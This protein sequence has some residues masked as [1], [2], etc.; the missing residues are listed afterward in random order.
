MK[1]RKQTD[2]KKG[3]KSTLRNGKVAWK[4]VPY[5]YPVSFL[6]YS[7]KYHLIKTGQSLQLVHYQ[8][9]EKETEISTCDAIVFQ[10]RLT[11]F[12]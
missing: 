9:I 2:I 1:K 4:A 8:I 7:F 12:S 3:L 11:R 5:G 10:R 6:R